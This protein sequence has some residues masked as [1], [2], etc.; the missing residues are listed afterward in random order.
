MNLSKYIAETNAKKSEMAR[1]LNVS[2][3]LLH[4]WVTGLR[5]V[6]IPHCAAIEIYTAGKVTR[7]DLRPNDWAQIWPDLAV[8]TRHKANKVAPP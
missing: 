2:P 3:A 4:Q 5:P 6:A 8:P 1:A 7:R